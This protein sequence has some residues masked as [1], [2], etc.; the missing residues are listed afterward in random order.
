MP[1]Q[2]QHPIEYLFNERRK[3][4]PYPSGVKPVP[5]ML[6]GTAF[7]P[8]GSGLWLGYSGS[9]YTLSDRPDMPKEKVMILGHNFDSEVGYK[10]TESLKEQHELES[11]TWRNLRELLRETDIQLEDCFFT[12]AFM[13][14]IEGEGNT[15]EFPGVNDSGFVQRC[16]SFLD[17]QIEMQQPRLILTLGSWVPW[18]IT[19]LSSGLAVW[20]GYESF[21]DLDVSGPV[22]SDVRFKGTPEK[23]V[24]VVALMHP[25]Q[26]RRNIWRRRYRGLKGEAAELAMLK[27]ALKQSGLY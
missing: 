25:S 23:P 1:T 14:L 17:R 10:Y 2:E 18:F 8:G 11:H 13:G 6:S 27:D 26:R 20:R 24:T 16:R 15:G 12:N 21:R 7:F 4:A 19:P 3:V 5:K 22:I 9:W